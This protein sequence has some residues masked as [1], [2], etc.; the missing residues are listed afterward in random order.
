MLHHGAFLCESNDIQSSCID[1]GEDLIAVGNAMGS[2]YFYKLCSRATR[3]TS[4]PCML[5]VAAPANDKSLQVPLTFIK[6]SPCQNFIAVG[7]DSG[8][9]LV[10]NLTDSTLN[11]KCRHDNHRGEAISALCWSADSSKLF[12]GCTGGF[13]IELILSDALSTSSM[14]LNFA[15]ALLMGTK[16]TTLIYQCTEIVRQIECTFSK[17]CSCGSGD[18]LLVSVAH[19]SLLFQLPKN[20]NVSPR[21]CDISLPAEA[22]EI[23]N[24]ERVEVKKRRASFD[25]LWCASC[26]CDSFA[27]A[28]AHIKNKQEV[29][30]MRH[31]TPED[32]EVVRAAGI[33]VARYCESGIELVF[34]TVDG[35]VIRTFKLITPF[36]YKGGDDDMESYHRGVRGVRYLRTFITTDLY[37]KYMTL[38][39][40]NNSIMLINLQDMSYDHLLGHY[41]YSVHAAVS[42][43]GKLLVLYRN[44][45]V[46]MIM[47]DLLEC[48]LPS[49]SNEPSRIFDSRLYLA[50][51]ILK[52]RMR[53]RWKMRRQRGIEADKLCHTYRNDRINNDLFSYHTPD[54][55]S[56][57]EKFITVTS[58]FGTASSHMGDQPLSSEGNHCSRLI[59]YRRLSDKEEARS[60]LMKRYI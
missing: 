20:K 54:Q 50:F 17:S 53:S 31:L 2:I 37:N 29:R 28:E 14:A 8:T 48:I 24:I 32:K 4:G 11:I 7:T 30:K 16:P 3:I 12:S 36:S 58:E 35:E 45:E 55:S 9:V 19:Q 15:S 56:E 49:R 57:A 13:V 26:F 23:A 44:V 38:I 1:Y 27:S 6:F 33:I 46:N 40:A 18:I 25:R 21:F 41:D 43:H 51:S 34:C 59:S 52:Q 22:E 47:I 60:I 42:S 5:H 10:C 39:T